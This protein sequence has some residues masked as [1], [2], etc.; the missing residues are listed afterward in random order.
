MA[1]TI[2][3]T[4]KTVKDSYTVTVDSGATILELKKEVEK[5]STVPVDEQRLIYA[6]HILKDEE[7][8]QKYGTQLLYQLIVTTRN[9]ISACRWL[10]SC[11]ST[12]HL[13]FVMMLN[14]SR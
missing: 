14:R 1:S 5:A 8:V 11:I 4:I 12:Y 2:S 6:G 7:T 13:R 3:I 10:L 9:L